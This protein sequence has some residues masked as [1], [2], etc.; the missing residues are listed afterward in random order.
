[1]T[2]VNFAAGARL[3]RL[4]GADDAG[5]ARHLSFLRCARARLY[6]YLYSLWQ[7]LTLRSE[8]IEDHWSVFPLPADCSIHS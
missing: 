4:R 7:P 8:F 6:L 2:H 5:A 3:V 1:M